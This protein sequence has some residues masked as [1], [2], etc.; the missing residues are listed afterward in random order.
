MRIFFEEMD[1][2][3]LIRM[4]VELDSNSL[5]KDNISFFKQIYGD[6]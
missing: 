6:I 4:M 3:K 5:V 2:N 1:F